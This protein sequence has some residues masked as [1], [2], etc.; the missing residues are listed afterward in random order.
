MDGVK[1]PVHILVRVMMLIIIKECISG[2]DSLDPPFMIKLALRPLMPIELPEQILNLNKHVDWIALLEL[3]QRFLLDLLFLFL[4]A[5][6]VLGEHLWLWFLV[7]VQHGVAQ[8][9]AV[10]EHLGCRVAVAYTCRELNLVKMTGPL[11]FSNPR[12][13]SPSGNCWV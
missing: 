1:Q 6:L 13:L 7:E 11:T 3:W 9:F 5:L 12:Y 2:L 8:G 10:E 4:L